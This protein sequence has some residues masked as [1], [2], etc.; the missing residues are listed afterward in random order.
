M[1]L[2]S[3]TFYFS[4]LIQIEFFLEGKL[5]VNKLIATAC[6]AELVF[7]RC[8]VGFVLSFEC[9]IN[10]FGENTIALVHFQESVQI[11]FLVLCCGK[12][13]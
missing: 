5:Q 3:N 13:E 8:N 9:S 7:I 1:F 2:E 6:I 11:L 12:F 10:M 4:I